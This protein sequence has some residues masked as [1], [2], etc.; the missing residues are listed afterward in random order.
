[1]KEAI[2]IPGYNIMRELG[3]GSMAIVYLA[4]Q[5]SLKRKVALKIMSPR[6]NSD[7]GFAARFRR[8]ACIFAQLSHA[9][10]VPV[11]DVGEY[12]SRCYLSMEYLPGGDLRSRLLSGPL[13][14]SE[15]SRICVALCDALDLAHR[16]G[17]VHQD[18]K[19]ENIL[20]RQDG[21]PVLTDFG[22]TR[23]SAPLGAIRDWS[24]WS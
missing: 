17:Y 19:P 10:I 13:S 5:H 11:F 6:L 4:V 16:K 18:I 9:S 12:Q 15:A 8:E 22:I 14:A 3:K 20:F 1:M 21:T 23:V 2:T 7:P 24:N